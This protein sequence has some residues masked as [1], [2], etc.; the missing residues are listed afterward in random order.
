MLRLVRRPKSPN[1]VIRGTVRGIR[2]EESAGTDDRKFAEEI[3]AKRES[4]ILAESVYGRRATCT[5]G[6]AA[7]SYLEGGG[8]K[9]FLALVLE[10]FGTTPLARIDQTAIESGARKTYP[11]TSNATLDRQF[12]T[13][14]SAVLRHAARRG[15]CTALI[16]DRPDISVPVI[17]WLSVEEANRLIDACGEHLRPLVIFLLFTGCR[18]GEALWLDWSN[19]DL[20]R[21]H[22]AFV[23]TKNGEA[24][25][26]PLH[27]RVVIALA[28]L[29]HRE[30]EVFRRPDGLPYER[31][32]P[33][34]PDDTSAGSRIKKAFA[35]ACRRAGISNFSVHGCRHTWATWHYIANRDVTA[36][37]R[38]GGWKT[39][40]MV[41]RYTHT[42]VDEHRH[43]IDR[44]IGGK[45]GEAV[46]SGAKSA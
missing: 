32:K 45:A 43:T 5:F 11:G 41:M 12:F 10:H 40:A 16:M 39:V 44:L 24:R 25:G 23:K 27:D 9:R 17:R 8:S 1:W 30:G 36:L 29:P 42:N 3:R 2:V 15:W 4:E 46:S 14:V 37:M 21:R 18:I 33:K 31:P 35:G 6:Q 22:V 7:L 20:A 13:P 26:V 19:I 34:R 28:N 38:L